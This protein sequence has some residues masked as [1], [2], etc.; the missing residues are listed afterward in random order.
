MVGIVEARK[1]SARCCWKWKRV[2]WVIVEVG[3]SA[4]RHQLTWTRADKPVG[5]V[6]G[7]KAPASA[8]STR[9]AY[10]APVRVHAGG[11]G[12]SSHRRETSEAR[13]QRGWRPRRLPS[14]ERSGKGVGPEMVRVGGG[15]RES[16]LDN[17]SLADGG[18]SSLNG[19][20]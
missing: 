8:G 10:L 9:G 19:P 14:C 18:G 4:Q 1:V 12:A 16:I 20:V 17:G 6:A 2:T 15:E 7:A 3:V 13:S 5:A 11:F